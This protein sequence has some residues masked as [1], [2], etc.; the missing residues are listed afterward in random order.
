METDQVIWYL[1]SKLH[2]TLINK[3]MLRNN[4]H[5]EVRGRSYMSQRFSVQMQHKKTE[6]RY[7]LKYFTFMS[8]KENMLFS[9]IELFHLCISM[10]M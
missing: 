5:A 6:L 3:S 4:A 9:R 7:S 10:F 8:F 2:G 1:E